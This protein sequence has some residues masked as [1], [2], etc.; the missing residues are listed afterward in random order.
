MAQ[1]FAVFANGGLKIVPYAIDSIRNSQDQVI[2]QAKPLVACNDQCG[3]NVAAAPR[4]ISEQNAFLITSA[5]RDVIQHGTAT[6]AKK[7]GR[8]DIAGKTGT[9]QNQVDAWFAGYNADI[10]AISWLGF[11][12]PQS[13]HEYGAQAALPM[14]MQFMQSALKGKPLHA[15]EQPQGI[16]SIRIDPMTGR[17]ASARDPNAMFEYFMLPH[18]PDED[19]G[20]YVATPEDDQQASTDE[21]EQLY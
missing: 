5:L 17:R 10:V 9:T 21:P 12:Q 19:N 6:L 11:D 3:P 14:W 8:T 7:L 1:A 20:T 16:V 13:L 18:V 15:L 2:Y 4:V